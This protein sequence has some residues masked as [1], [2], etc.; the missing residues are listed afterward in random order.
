MTEVAATETKQVA[1]IV[2]RLLIEKRPTESNATKNG[3]GWTSQCSG[4]MTSRTT[5]HHFCVYFFV[6]VVWQPR[7][8]RVCW[9]HVSEPEEV[10]H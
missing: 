6:P 5:V 1:P 4:I 2:M 9:C 8:V 7:K 10:S 3:W